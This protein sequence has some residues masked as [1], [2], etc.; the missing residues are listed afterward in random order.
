MED[1]ELLLI[2]K[3]DFDLITK[4]IPA[5]QMLVQT[6]QENNVIASQNRIHAA[7]SFSAEEKYLDFL[8]TYPDLFKRLPQQMVASYLGITRETL[9]RVRRQSVQSK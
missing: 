5:L 8:T 4:K 2:T 1:S 6:I 9:S 7:I 3:E